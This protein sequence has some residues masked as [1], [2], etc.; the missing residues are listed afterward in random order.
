MKHYKTLL[1]VNGLN[2]Q[3]FAGEKIDSKIRS[4]TQSISNDISDELT[5]I[6]PNTS[7]IISHILRGGRI[8]TASSTTIEW[9]DTYERKTSS[10]LKVTLN[11]GATEIQ[12]VD[13]DVLVKDALLSIDDEIVKIT[14][15][16]T[17]NKADVIRGYAGTT[18]T[19]GNI[20]ANTI[21]QSLGIEIEEG[22]ELKDSTVRLSKHITNITGIIYDKYEITETMK[23]THP[24][25]QGG[26]SAREI[27][28]QKK[29]DE[30]LGTMENKL[31]NGIKYINGDIRHS[32]GIKSLIKEHGIVLDAGN[33]PFSIDLLTTAVK[34]IVD[35]GNPGAADLQSGKYFVCV[36]WAI[37]VQ[38]NK[39]NKDFAR[40]DI[41]EKVTGS[42]ITEIVTNAGVVSVFPAMSLAANEFLLIN[43]NEVSLEQLYPIKEEL[44]AKTRLADTYFFHGEYA[45]KIKKLPF[46]VH[47][48]NVK[49]S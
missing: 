1:G 44:A 49:I 3:L 2:I 10:T 38:I 43:L 30:L 4:T 34:A 21:V 32:A 7:Q 15:V 13:A 31:L 17:D 27:E 5:L 35:K 16:K 33:Q 11:A 28:S 40:T 8:G 29:K 22:G 20:V 36:P 26:L 23:H 48:K 42:K 25:G 14:K 9:V 6:N 37:G 41:T 24:Q 47:V 46:Q 39:M 45:H 19:A 18:S 12:V